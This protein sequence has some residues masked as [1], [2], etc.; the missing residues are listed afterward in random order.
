M[1]SKG[2]AR[3]TGAAAWATSNIAVAFPKLAKLPLELQLMV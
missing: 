1:V 2:P 3:R